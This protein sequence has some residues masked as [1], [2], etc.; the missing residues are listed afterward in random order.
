[1]DL[2]P[3]ISL[4]AKRLM[5]ILRESSLMIDL[6]KN[7]RFHTEYPFAIDIC[8]REQTPCSLLKKN[9]M[10]HVIYGRK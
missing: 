3:R 10:W 1:L 8:R 2:T 6:P 5:S 4:K 7:R 9:I